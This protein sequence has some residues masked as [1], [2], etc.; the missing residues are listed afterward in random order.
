[1]NSKNR[2]IIL[3]LLA[4]LII[5]IVGGIAL[6]YYL[7]PQKTTIYVFRENVQ[8]G[9]RVTSDMLI[10][11]QA[12]SEIFVAGASVSASDRFVTGENIDAILK[13]GDSLRMDVTSGMPLTLSLL[14]T[15]GGSS[16]EMNMNPQKIAITVPINSITGITGELKAGSR[17]NVYVT[18][19]YSENGLTTLLLFENMRV[20]NTGFKNNELHSV[21]LETTI[22]ESLK[23]IY[24]TNTGT[25]YLGLID[26]TGYEY[27]NTPN[28][29]PSYVPNSTSNYVDPYAE[30][31]KTVSDTTENPSDT[32]IESTPQT[33]EEI[34]GQGNIQE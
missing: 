27:S 31:G 4:A 6:Y 14:T 29:T 18:G 15:S 33:T 3:I 34:P 25:I 2:K 13:S 21:T 7:V 12:D 30:Q 8:A 32:T 17:V 1:M 24:Y 9:E 23:L 26:S 11:V 5:A 10:P 19:A 28:E 16:I 20:L 22:E